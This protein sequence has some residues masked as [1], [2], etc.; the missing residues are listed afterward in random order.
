LLDL[1]DIAISLG[2]VTAGAWALGRL[3]PSRDTTMGWVD[4]YW[5]A[6]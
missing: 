4:G 6:G 2:G 5:M 1:P 3:A